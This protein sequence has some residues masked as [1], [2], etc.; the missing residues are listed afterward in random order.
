MQKNQIIG[1]NLIWQLCIDDVSFEGKDCWMLTLFAL[2]VCQVHM[3]IRALM[4]CLR[5]SWYISYY[6]NFDTSSWY[7]A[8]VYPRWTFYMESRKTFINSGR[9]YTVH[10]Y[11][12]NK[13]HIFVILDN[14]LLFVMLIRTVP[15]Y[16][17]YIK[18]MQCEIFNK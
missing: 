15:T 6:I 3:C 8:T 10:I 11:F 13:F 1:T 2:L 7:I 16:C 5:Q 4:L 12:S 14:L 9:W 18:S 17:I